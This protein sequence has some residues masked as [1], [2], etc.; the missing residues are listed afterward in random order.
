M[1][2]CYCNI[3]DS[4]ST[5]YN[6]NIFSYFST[7]IYLEMEYGKSENMKYSMDS[8]GAHV[9]VDRCGWDFAKARLW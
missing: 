7:L 8:P 4:L 6:R 9:H 2:V 5:D 3:K 1:Y